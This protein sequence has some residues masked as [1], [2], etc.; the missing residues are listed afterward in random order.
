MR[1]G[2][3]AR[4]AFIVPGATAMALVIAGF[5]L[6][7][8]DNKA[9]TGDWKLSP[10]FVFQ[11]TYGGPPAFMAVKWDRSEPG[12]YASTRVQRN[13][14]I[15]S[16][17]RRNTWSGVAK[18]E[19]YRLR[20]YWNFYVG[21][22]LSIPFV[23]GAWA[24]RRKPVVVLAAISLGVALSIG[25]FDFAHYA[26]PGFGL[27]MLAVMLGFQVLRGWAPGGLP[28]GLSLS[29]TLPMALVL[30]TA[31]PLS[32][33][34]FDTPKFPMFTDNSLSAPCCWLRPRSLHAAVE[35]EVR[36]TEGRDLIVADNGPGAPMFEVLIANEPVVADA[37]TIWINDDPEYNAATIERYPGRR[38]WRLGWLDD[39]S[40]CLQLFESAPTQ[41]GA[42]LS[43]RFS[44]LPEDPDRGWVAAPSGQCPQGLTRPPWTVSARR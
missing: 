17:E 34:V 8:A 11:R 37:R 20:N 23:L 18:A 38:V 29:R 14:D 21:F 9:I 22:A 41:N 43:G 2:P 1:S 25:S 15:L 3:D 44:K 28:L 19:S 35:N 24:L 12:G 6:T 36:R 42:S 5:G 32:S 30:G 13:S 33:A 26:S 31:I 27:V 16:Y 39:G 7:F 4:K 10:Y 40:P